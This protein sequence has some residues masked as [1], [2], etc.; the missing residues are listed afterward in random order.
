MTRPTPQRHPPACMRMPPQR[1]SWWPAAGSDGRR[2]PALAAG[3]SESSC[4]IFL[5]MGTCRSGRECPAARFSPIQLFPLVHPGETAWILHFPLSRKGRMAVLRGGSRYGSGLCL[6]LNGPA[7]F[8][9]PAIYSLPD[10]LL[11][12]R[13]LIRSTKK[14]STQHCLTKARGCA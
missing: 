2:G 10:D 12:I 14:L 6:Q 13:I 8:C 11:S 5:V 7:K 1:P 3:S 9:Q 4:V